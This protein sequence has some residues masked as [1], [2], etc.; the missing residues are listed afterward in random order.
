VLTF[1]EHNVDSPLHEALVLASSP[2]SPGDHLRARRWRHPHRRLRGH[3]PPSRA[4]S[5]RRPS[6]TSG[7]CSA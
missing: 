4:T 6:A 1:I 3:R 5:S 2:S 7:S